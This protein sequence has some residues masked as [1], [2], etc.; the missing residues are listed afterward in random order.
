M[1]KR[2][3]VTIYII[4]G[5]VILAVFGMIFFFRNE[6]VRQDF[7]SEMSNVV[8]PAQLKPVK[9]YIDECIEDTVLRGARVLGS[10][11]GY[12]EIPE[13]D[14]P[15]SVVNEFSN[16]LMLGE[17]EV[18]Y[19]YY[20]SANNLDKTQI[21]TEESMEEELEKYINENFDF[22]LDGLED[23]LYEGFEISYDYDVS[24]QVNIEDTH[25]EVR[26]F[27]PT[28]IS[29]GEVGQ[30]YPQ[31]LVDVKNNLGKLYKLALDVYEEENEN[32]FLEEKTIDMMVVYDDIPFSNTEFTCNRKSWSK[33][34]VEDNFREIVSFNMNALR[35][36]GSDYVKTMEDNDYFEVGVSSSDSITTN[37]EYMPSWPFG[38]EVSP[39]KGELLVGDSIT[40]GN[41]DISKY[42]NLFFCMNNYHFVYDVKY[43]VL[44]SLSDE[45]GYTFQFANMVVI[46]KNTPRQYEGE[47]LFY[48]E[49]GALGEEFCENRINDID[50]LVLDASN[51]NEIANVDISYSCMS[52]SCYLGRTNMFGELIDKFP[53]C[54]NGRIYADKEG[55]FSVPETLSTDISSKV[56]ILMEPYYELDVEVKVIDSV[57]GAERSLESGEEAIF[58]LRN[59]DNGYTT[60]IISDAEA[61]LVAGEYEVTSY[62]MQEGEAIKIEGQ[63]FTECYDVPRTGLFGLLGMNKEECFETSVEDSEIEEFVSGGAVFNFDL[64]HYSLESGNKI[65]LYAVRSGTPENYED[66]VSIVENLASNVNNPNFKYPEIK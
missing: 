9:G 31:H 15:R 14:I 52:S 36:K 24:S 65:V 25:I 45:E 61:T 41:P 43:P 3:Q 56:G 39:S 60:M 29:L 28:D 7:E 48:D 66:M 33:S 5:I 6:L 44:V 2:G 26:V 32:K 19:W 54:V 30:Y 37:F 20:K 13:D 11:G 49:S 16:S 35:L 23:Y 27:A 63:T 42:M 38:M 10:S 4:V 8:I 62:L 51:M 17:N 18:A 21:P 58:Q 55:Y 47:I 57:S 46:D 64:D 22:C 53:A 34:N 59:L 12:L 50:V 1:S 40:Q